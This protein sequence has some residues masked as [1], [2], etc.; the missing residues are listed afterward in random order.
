MKVREY[1][2]E[3]TVGYAKNIA[4]NQARKFYAY[5]TVGYVP[6]F[7]KNDVILL[8]KISGIFGKQL[9]LAY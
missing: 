6:A 8:A 5:P 4:K 3:Y 1:E 9:I 7:E 2:N